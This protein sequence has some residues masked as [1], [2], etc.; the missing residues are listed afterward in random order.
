MS[1]DSTGSLQVVFSSLTYDSSAGVPVLALSPQNDFVYF[2][3][4]MGDVVWVHSEN[5]SSTDVHEV[6]RISAPIRD[7]WLH[8]LTSIESNCDK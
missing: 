7:T 4:D 8:I 3:D 5:S 2:A 1:V 6:Q